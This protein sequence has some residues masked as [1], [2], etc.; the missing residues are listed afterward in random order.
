MSERDDP[1]VD[2][3]L[4]W[5][6]YAAA[7][8]LGEMWAEAAGVLLAEIE[9]H[10]AGVERVHALCADAQD[11]AEGGG[12]ADVDTLWPSHVLRALHG[13]DTDDA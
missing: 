10:R 13:D 7:T 4:D 3:A 9:R 2:E 6:R 1:T 11:E 12:M 5:L 8:P